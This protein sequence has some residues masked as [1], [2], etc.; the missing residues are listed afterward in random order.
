MVVSLDF[1]GYI[2]NNKWNYDVE[3]SCFPY[4]IHAFMEEAVLG[5]G[6][7]CWVERKGTSCLGLQAKWATFLCGGWSNGMQMI[8]ADSWSTQW[9]DA[10]GD[11][12]ARSYRKAQLCGK[13]RWDYEDAQNP[14]FR[15]SVLVFHS[16]PTSFWVLITFSGFVY[17]VV[18]A[19]TC[20]HMWFF[21][22]LNSWFW[23]ERI[24]LALHPIYIVAT[25]EAHMVKTI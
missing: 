19:T 12:E 17:L 18:E 2:F 6:R 23:I 13:V 15:H 1:M 14:S 7:G 5:L 8:D 3:F 24:M 4:F 16:A 9:L 25:I 20:K 11:F 10:F 21:H 22:H